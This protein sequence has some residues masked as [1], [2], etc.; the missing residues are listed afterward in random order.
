MQIGLRFLDYR[1]L[2]MACILALT[3]C[4]GP[5]SSVT[6][7]DTPTTTAPTTGSATSS[8]IAAEP[9]QAAPLPTTAQTMIN[10]QLLELEIAQTSEEQRLGLMC[11]DTLPANRGMIFPFEPARPV[12]FWMFQVRFPLDII[13]I[14]NQVVVGI[15]ANVPGCPQQPCQSYGPGRDVAVDLVLELNGGQA[16][17]LGLV[18]GDRVVIERL[19]N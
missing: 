18:V 19:E 15:A 11:R 12:S 17:A 14:R 13:F 2:L 1:A 16:A 10:G 5:S 4:G 3:A 9:C 7:S 6:S 8:P